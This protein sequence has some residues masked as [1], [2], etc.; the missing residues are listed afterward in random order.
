MSTDRMIILGSRSPRRFELLSQLL[1]ETRIQVL[2]PDDATEAGFSGLKTREQI[3]ERLTTIARTKNDTVRNQLRPLDQQTPPD[4]AGILTADTVVIADNQQ[5]LIVLEKP[6]GPDWEQKTRH[7]FQ[8]YYSERT[9]QVATAVCLRTAEEQI[10]ERLVQT[11]IR[12]CQVTSEM[13]DWYLSTREPLGKAGGYGL[14]GAA[15]LFVTAVHGS[16]S[17]VV[18]LPLLETRQLLQTCQ[19]L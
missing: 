10:V 3:H 7:W 1:P 5:S 16:P 17:N 9:H 12:F 2:A 18:G 19:L 8:H 15:A 13:L 6:D 11:E 14:Q 4:W